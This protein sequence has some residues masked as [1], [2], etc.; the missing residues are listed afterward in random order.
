MDRGVTCWPFLRAHDLIPAWTC[1]FPPLASTVT[2]APP[3]APVSEPNPEVPQTF[4]VPHANHH[5]SDLRRRAP[6]RSTTSAPLVIPP[7]N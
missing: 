3:S 1:I 4:S 5:A 2:K 6:P 7:S